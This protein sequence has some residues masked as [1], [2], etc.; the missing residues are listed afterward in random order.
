[1]L[2]KSIILSIANVIPHNTPF[3]SGVQ[4]GEEKT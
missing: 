4:N 2:V 3:W 1:M